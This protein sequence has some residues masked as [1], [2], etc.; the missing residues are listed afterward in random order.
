[1]SITHGD[2]PYS[3]DTWQRFLDTQHDIIEEGTICAHCGFQIRGMA[4]IGDRKVCHTDPPY[5]DCYR[6]VTVMHE[7]IGI[8][9]PAIRSVHPKAVG[10]DT[11]SLVDD[12]EEDRLST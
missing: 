2:Y 9:R 12:D 1:M 8:R 11:V 6:L 7:Q 5:P 3:I 4:V 10:N